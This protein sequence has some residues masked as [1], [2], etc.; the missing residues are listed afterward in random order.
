M[1]PLLKWIVSGQF[2]CRIVSQV[3]LERTDA[4]TAVVK[5]PA[6]AA[7]GLR[8]FTGLEPSRDPWYGFRCSMQ[9]SLICCFSNLSWLLLDLCMLHPFFAAFCSLQYTFHLGW[10]L[11]HFEVH[12]SHFRS[13]FIAFLEF[14]RSHLSL[15]HASW[16]TWQLSFGICMQSCATN[17]MAT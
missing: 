17:K 1:V 10:Y 9:S 12:T 7:E 6:R 11:Q 16:S 3:T 14:C 8:Q 15:L 4:R 5:S 13:H 2:W